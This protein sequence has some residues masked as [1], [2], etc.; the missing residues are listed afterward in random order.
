MK[1]LP[2]EREIKSD[3]F[4]LFPSGYWEKPTKDE[5]KT[6]D[7]NIG[8]MFQAVGHALSQWEMVEE[9]LADLFLSLCE[10]KDDSTREKLARTFGSIESSGARLTV[11]KDRLNIYLA[12]HLKT[13]KLEQHVNWF[14]S[15]L[16]DAVSAASPRRNEIAHGIVY[17]FLAQ[18][19][20]ELLKFNGVYLVSPKYLSGRNA[21][22]KNSPENDSLWF[23]SSSYA[24]NANEV[25]G[26]A[27]KFA[28]L[29]NKV[30]Q[31]LQ[32]LSKDDSGTPKFVVDI[33]KAHEQRQEH[34]K[35]KAEHRR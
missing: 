34:K 13:P 31:Y 30:E 26:M 18:R 1:P 20:N 22:K 19:N 10:C 2:H 27:L 24:Y 14:L 11:L 17:T 5:S 8:P 28:A 25:G 32:D 35:Q 29:G 21:A 7:H 6:S 3:D 4:A 15:K 16:V 33:E 12:P 23:V 9:K